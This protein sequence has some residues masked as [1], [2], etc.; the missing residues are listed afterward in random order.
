MGGFLGSAAAASE[1]M[2]VGQA[3]PHCHQNWKPDAYSLSASVRYDAVPVSQYSAPA[4]AKSWRS[5][6]W[7]NAYSSHTCTA[8]VLS[9]H[10]QHQRFTR[11][12]GKVAGCTYSRRG[13]IAPTRVH[14]HASASHGNR[15]EVVGT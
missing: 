13:A 15:K 8:T 1:I 9:M 14:R 10:A 2:P 11:R 3:W 4:A 12:V 5:M 6:F 7:L